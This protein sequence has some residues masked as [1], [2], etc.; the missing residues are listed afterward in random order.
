[1]IRYTLRRL[2]ALV[3]VLIGVSVIVFLFL[4]LIPG[5]PARAFDRARVREKFLRF[6]APVIEAEEAE[7]ILVRCG[8]VLVDGRFE[9]LM[10]DIGAICRVRSLAT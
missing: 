6:V 7:R 3:P 10:E 9:L 5:D 2:V 8:D 1:M 4:H